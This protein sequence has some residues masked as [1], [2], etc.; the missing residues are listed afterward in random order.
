AQKG[1]K[2][3]QVQLLTSLQHF[4]QESQQCLPQHIAPMSQHATFDPSLQ[5]C[6]LAEQHIV[7]PQHLVPAGQGSQHNFKIILAE[8]DHELKIR[9]LDDE[10]EYN[11]QIQDLIT[12]LMC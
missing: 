8:S 1:S 12:N 2:L 7:F 6:L 3:G 10:S 9:I 5:H 11:S 4:I